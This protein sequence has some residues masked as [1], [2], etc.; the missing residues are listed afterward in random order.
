LSCITRE[1]R[2]SDLIVLENFLDVPHNLLQTTSVLHGH[3]RSNLHVLGGRAGGRLM[4]GLGLLL[5]GRDGVVVQVSAGAVS[6][7]MSVVDS[8]VERNWSRGAHVVVRVLKDEGLQLSGLP[9]ALVEDALVV[10][11]S[12]SALDG[13]VGAEVKVELEGMSAAR[14]H[15]GTRQRVVISIALAC[16][17]KEADMTESC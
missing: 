3:E 13:H 7:Q 9:L 5:A 15:Q 1:A 10:D 16:L 14:L 17:G 4:V 11:G 6:C 12:S 8:R 2:Q